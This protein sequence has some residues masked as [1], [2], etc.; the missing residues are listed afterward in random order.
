[1]LTAATAT[2]EGRVEQILAAFRTRGGRSTAPRRAVLVALLAAESHPT[3]EALAATVQRTHPDVHISTI[4]RTLDQLEEM[5][6]V[7]HV[8]LGHDPAVYH[9]ADQTH[10]HLV[11]GQCR[12]TV[13]LPV[14]VV[15][16]MSNS[17][18]KAVGFEAD[19]THFSITGTCQTCCTAPQPPE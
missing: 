18:R 2:T 15:G 9:L 4:Y 8:H 7:V 16:S 19:L 3:A 1:M 12:A 14:S 5:E 6:I 13:E 17:I 10:V 11:C